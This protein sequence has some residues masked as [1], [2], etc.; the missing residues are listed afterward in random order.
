M[1]KALLN[2]IKDELRM[3]RRLRS[4][5]FYEWGSFVADVQNLVHCLKRLTLTL[6]R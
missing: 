4:K 1:D 6:V 3:Q 2:E 5:R